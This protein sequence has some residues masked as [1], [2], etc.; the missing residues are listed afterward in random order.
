MRDTTGIFCSVT[1]HSDDILSWIQWT[2]G[3]RI[4][5][6]YCQTSQVTSM[7][8]CKCSVSF[9][10][11]TWNMF[12]IKRTNFTHSM[13]QTTVILDSRQCHKYNFSSGIH[14]WW[15]WCSKSKNKTLDSDTTERKICLCIPHELKT[16]CTVYIHLLAFSSL[17]RDGFRFKGSLRVPTFIL[18]TNHAKLLACWAHRRL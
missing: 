2:G 4:S 3:G 16:V 6:T 9:L 10:L 14:F 15:S 12:Y 13:G 8:A 11:K 1:S 7:D 5:H 18:K 17:E